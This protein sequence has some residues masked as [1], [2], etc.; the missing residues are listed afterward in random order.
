MKRMRRYVAACALA[1]ALAA[2]P[3]GPSYGA[4]NDE[5]VYSMT[6]GVNR[7]H[8]HPA[9]KATLYPVTVVVDTALLPFTVIAGF[10]TG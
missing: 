6:R 4:F 1:V 5:Y 9:A 8:A 3:S 10:V 2:V 7:M